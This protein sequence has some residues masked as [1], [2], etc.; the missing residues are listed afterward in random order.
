VVDDSVLYHLMRLA[1]EGPVEVRAMAALKLE[2]LRSYLAEKSAADEAQQAHLKFGAAQIAR[3]LS[4]PS[5]FVFPPAAAA[6][7]GAPIGLGEMPLPWIVWDD[8]EEPIR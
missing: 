5:K 4:D 3:Y 6:P 2:Q 1:G 8:P 7:P